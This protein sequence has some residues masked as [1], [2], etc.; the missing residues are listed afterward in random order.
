LHSMERHYP[1]DVS[2]SEEDQAALDAAQAEYD[3]LAE[4][5][6]SGAAD[7]EAEAKLEEVEKRIDA[8]TARAE[9]FC[10][11]ALANGGAF[12]MLDYYGRLSIERGF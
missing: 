3:E 2:L 12:V 10:S 5:I 6:E 11:E 7:D 1:E 4:L 8:L 9:A